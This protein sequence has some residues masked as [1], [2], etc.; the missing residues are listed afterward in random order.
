MSLD[1]NLDIDNLLKLNEFNVLTLNIPCPY[2]NK[3][4]TCVIDPSLEIKYRK[5]IVKHNSFLMDLHIYDKHNKKV[6]G[7][8]SQMADIT[9]KQYERL[10]DDP[11]KFRKVKPLPK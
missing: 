1:D 3:V 5:N 4:V 10:K 9:F 8:D 6:F 7:A 2:C 11:T